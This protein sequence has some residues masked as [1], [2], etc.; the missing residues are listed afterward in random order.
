M[1]GEARGRHMAEY[2][3]DIMYRVKPAYRPKDHGRLAIGLILLATLGM[4]G[5][6][7]FYLGNHKLG[8]AHLVLILLMV[9]TIFSL[10]LLLTLLGIQIL[11]LL[12]E[13]VLMVI[14]ET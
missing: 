4:T 9:P 11:M 1:P 3:G 12:G 14:E 7:Q 10:S 6:H 2:H 13:A 5:I 8:Y